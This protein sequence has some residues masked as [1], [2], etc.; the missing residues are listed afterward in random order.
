LSKCCWYKETMRY[1]LPPFTTTE[2]FEKGWIPRPRDVA[3]GLYLFTEKIGEWNAI[4]PSIY[5]SQKDSWEQYIRLIPFRERGFSWIAWAPPKWRLLF[6]PFFVRLKS[7][8]VLVAGWQPDV[9]TIVT[10]RGPIDLLNPDAVKDM[11]KMLTGLQPYSEDLL[12]QRYILLA[13][14]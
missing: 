11:H 4:M 3:P 1:P 5:H 6:S 7:E 12:L 10:N 8:E 9:L 14:A 13:L 2:L